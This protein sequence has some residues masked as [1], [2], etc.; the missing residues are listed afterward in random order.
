MGEKLTVQER[1][2]LV[3]MFGR[4]VA[5]Y[6]SVT[7]KFNHNH[8]K[9]EQPLSHTTVCHLIKSFQ[10]TGSVAD[11]ERSG[12]RKSATDEETSTMVLASFA[13]SPMKSVRK[14]SQELTISKSSVRRILKTQKFHQYKVHLVQALHGNDT[15][16]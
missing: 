5:T 9:P 8:P 16:S 14:I 13:R 4:D 3:F 15:D 11:S 2:K 6:R 10:K 12:R 7:Q 1:V